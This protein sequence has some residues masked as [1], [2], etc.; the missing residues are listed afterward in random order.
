MNNL[1]FSNAFVTWE[2]QAGYPIINVR[3]DVPTQS[4]YI[5]Q[6]K[7]LSATE[8][9]I[10]ND[11]AS[12]YIPLSFTTAV[13]R[14]FEN[15]IFTDYF[16]NNQAFKAIPTTNIP[17]FD[18]SQWY[19]FNI[20][21]IGY[22]RVNYE[23]SNWQEIIKILNSNDYTKI[24]VL[25]RAQLVDDALTLAFDGY[26]SYDIALGVV[27]YLFRE[28]DYIPWYPAVIAF[29]KLDYILKGTPLHSQFKRFIRMMV[30]RLHVTYGMEA[31]ETDGVNEHFGRELGIDWTCRMGDQ[32][33][34]DYAFNQI[35]ISD[36]IPKPLGITFMCNG[37]K[38]NNRT[39]YFVDIHRRFV[40][41][42]DQ[43]D[44][45]R[46]IDGLTC[47]SDVTLLVDL[48]QS[49]LGSEIAYRSHE[50]SRIY[51]NMWT[52]SSVGL[53]AM[54]Q[55]ILQ[56]YNEIR[57]VNGNVFDSWFITASRRVVS[58]EDEAL[59]INTMNTL[60]ATNRGISQSARDQV[61]ANINFNKAWVAS[62][63]YEQIML[64]VNSHLKEIDDFESQL[65]IPKL[66]EPLNYKIHLDTRNAFSG[67]LPFTGEVTIDVAIKQNTDKIFFHSKNQVINEIKVFD[68]SGV[69]IQVLDYSLQTSAD[70]LTIYFM[71]Q[72]LAGSQITITI[73]Y[74][75]RLLTSSTGF[76][77]TF[78]NE[79]GVTKYLAATQFQPTSAR[80]AFPHYDEPGFKT[81]FELSI[82][83]PERYHA[84]ANTFGLEFPK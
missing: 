40:G 77:R 24:H 51:S 12:W 26:L 35:Q 27:S 39:P 52:R 80:Y 69:E 68:K 14:N 33:C 64:F 28:T 44:R 59:I 23:Q 36:N 10:P 17:E 83:H 49:T 19:I 8:E 78:Y 22:Y 30:R 73:K 67:L 42:S 53:E 29:D 21:Q 62:P 11:P 55:F 6:E 81:P 56:L 4:F 43:A 63:R 74:S 5:T 65:R 9:P 61:M 46:Y 16:I 70:S 20:Q 79:N 18:G 38:G 25:N 7:Y 66:S 54:M 60:Q 82:T 1:N 3:Y 41:S 75:T 58:W 71:S 57:S 45:L 37:L 31:R 47:S 48:L 15:T 34:L 72:L 2:L 13:N 50:R 32:R 76:Y 84:I